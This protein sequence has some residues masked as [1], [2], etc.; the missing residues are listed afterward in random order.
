M[1]RKT[2]ALEI[3]AA[4][5]DL[6]RRYADFLGEMTDLAATAPDGSVLDV[7]EEAV[8]A[9]GREHQRRLLEHAVQSRLDAVEKK[10]T[11]FRVKA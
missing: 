5:E 9:K 6:L 4:H 8:I 11:V 1:S 7:C 3:D 10:A 2:I